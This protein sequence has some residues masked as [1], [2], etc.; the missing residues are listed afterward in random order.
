MN[1]LRRQDL[2]LTRT[3]QH[4]KSKIPPYFNT[5]VLHA[6][7]EKIQTWTKHRELQNVNIN[8]HIIQDPEMNC[9]SEFINFSLEFIPNC[10]VN[11]T[12]EKKKVNYHHY[13][14]GRNF[15]GLVLIYYFLPV[16]EY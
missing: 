4:Q 3:L 16:R 11:K 5:V 1:S 12:G 9:N 2:A 6:K 14:S 10:S 15:A 13:L 7:K 8:K